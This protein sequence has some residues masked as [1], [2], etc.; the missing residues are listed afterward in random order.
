MLRVGLR[1]PSSRNLA[2]HKRRNF[3]SF[4]PCGV[5]LVI[6]LAQG[7]RWASFVMGGIGVMIVVA[8]GSDP[9]SK[10]GKNGQ[11]DPN[12]PFSPGG[13]INGGNPPPDLTKCATSSA[14]PSPIPVNLV[15]MF[16]Q[17]GSMGQD[18]KWT[19]CVQGL[20]GFFADPNSKGLNASLQYFP[21]GTQCST[22][23]VQT[24]A[25]AIRAL[26][27]NQSFASS[28]SSHMPGGGTPTL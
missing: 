25:V 24:P 19:S 28:M 11:N 16:D 14:T 15:F 12:D 5:G 7:M 9:G 4:L 22:S 27:D 20:T 8:C 23:V 10:F 26:P 6:A 13:M 17:S 18:S 3:R 21:Q 1:C 2:R